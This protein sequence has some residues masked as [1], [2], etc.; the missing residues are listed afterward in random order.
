MLDEVLEVADDDNISYETE[1]EYAEREKAA[2]SMTLVIGGAMLSIFGLVCFILN[3][4]SP[5]KS[6]D[7]S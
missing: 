2:M 3:Q 6:I 1:A 4:C 7:E 5:R